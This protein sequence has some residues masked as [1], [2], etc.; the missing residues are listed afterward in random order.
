MRAHVKGDV[1]GD[2]YYTAW[3]REQEMLLAFCKQAEKSQAA[4]E[5]PPADDPAQVELLDYRAAFL[6]RGGKLVEAEQAADLQAA[7]GA[8]NGAALFSAGRRW[9]V[10]AAATVG[11]DPARLR[12]EARAVELLAKAADQGYYRAGA[13][14]AKLRQADDFQSLQGRDD[15]RALIERV[16]Q[17]LPVDA[18]K[19]VGDF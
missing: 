9:A 2:E 6:T 11:D 17:S 14:A 8:K 16:K 13:A 3:I 5:P 18:A 10:I 12:R 19:A 1:A 4:A 7:R 15:Y